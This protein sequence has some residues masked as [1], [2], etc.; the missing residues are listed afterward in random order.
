MS[1]YLASHSD[2]EK[3]TVMICVDERDLL[4]LFGKALKSK[5]SAHNSTPPLSKF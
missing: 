5:H 1:N 2:T 3:K 4:E